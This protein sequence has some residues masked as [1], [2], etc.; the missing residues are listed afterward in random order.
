MQDRSAELN[1]K[2]ERE[3]VEQEKSEG[4]QGAASKGC[5]AQIDYQISESNEK[6]KRVSLIKENAIEG[7]ECG[8]NGGHDLALHFE[9]EFSGQGGSKLT[10]LTLQMPLS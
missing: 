10:L 9:G 1:E 4:G 5:E 7:S 3:K 2:S 8:E 6:E